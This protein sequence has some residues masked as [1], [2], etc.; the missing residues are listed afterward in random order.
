M[1]TLVFTL[2][3]E[4]FALTNDGT[5]VWLQYGTDETTER[6]TFGALNKAIVNQQ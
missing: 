1:H 5:D 6:W 4:Q 2:T 3:P